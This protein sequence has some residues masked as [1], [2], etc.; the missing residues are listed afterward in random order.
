MSPPTFLIVTGLSGAGKT[1]AS[2]FL[3]DLGFFRID[4][5]PPA[6]ISTFA[7]L[8]ASAKTPIPRV[9]LGIDIRG[10]EFFADLFHE[11]DE[12]EKA[13]FS[14]R[15]LFLDA[16][17]ATLVNRYKETRRRHPLSRSEGD[18]LSC[19]R[20]ERARL[21]EVRERADI[22]INTTNESVWK[23]RDELIRLFGEEE[24]EQTPMLIQVVSFGFK[25]GV[26]LDVDLVFDVRF[27]KNPNYEQNLACFDGRH[28]AVREFLMN[29]PT[30]IEF[31]RHLRDFLGFLVPRFVAEGKAYLSIALGCTGGRHRSVCLAE[32]VREFLT[33][34]GYT[35]QVVHR[36]VEKDLGTAS[37]PDEGTSP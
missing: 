29:D 14:H 25:Y 21:A 12:L 17:D 26:P 15:I 10:G 1:Q 13:G 7:R 4:N 22:L 33:G 8:C 3:E 23:L 27:L 34:Q 19:I 2:H 18:L 35:A 9:A 36:D 6:L 28:P 24:T 37:R 11:L 30:T 31:D 32:V 20:T 16:E 5:L